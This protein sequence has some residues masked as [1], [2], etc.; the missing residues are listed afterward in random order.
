MP[1][2]VYYINVKYI[3]ESNMR[4]YYSNLSKVRKEKVD[5]LKF[6]EDKR[7]SIMAEILLKYALEKE[8]IAFPKKILESEYGKP[9]IDGIHFNISH[10]KEYVVVAVSKEEVGCDIEKV[11]NINLN[12]AIEK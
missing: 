3:S 12:I 1:V 7:L 11:T 2:K 10:S 8:R 5:R 4:S 6:S 9:Y